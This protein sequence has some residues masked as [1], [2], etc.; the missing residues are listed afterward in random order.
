M[1]GVKG[2]TGGVGL[3]PLM[4][5]FDEGAV[6]AWLSGDAKAEAAKRR[7]AKVERCMLD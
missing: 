2:G 5:R 4:T 6:R 3:T 7:D 1:R